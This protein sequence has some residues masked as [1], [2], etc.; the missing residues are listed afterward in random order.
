M[1][2]KNVKLYALDYSDAKTYLAASLFVLGNIALPQ[3]F[4]LVPQGGVTWLPI[5]FFTL[6]GA[7]KFGWKVGLLTAVLSPVLNSWL[8][9][10]PLPAVLPAILLKSVLLA[11]AA[12]WTAHRYQRVSLPIL[13]AVVLFY[14]IAGT[15]GEWAMVG[16][17]FSAA[18]DFR[19]GVPG[20]LLQ[21][22]GGYLLLKH[23]K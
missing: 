20:M 7:Y 3:L 1:E 15:L 4:H 14:Q 18:Q 23:S 6:I 19:I 2:T 10:M 11:I 21:V 8:F 17:F 5:Y 9:G 13:L 16:N 12:G 22:I